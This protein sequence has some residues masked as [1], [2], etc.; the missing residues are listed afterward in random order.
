[1]KRNI[2]FGVNV[3]LFVATYAI[4]ML[5]AM[6]KID[7]PP[8]LLRSAAGIVVIQ[9]ASAM[10]ALFRSTNFFSPDTELNGDAWDL[11]A[12]LWKFQKKCFPGDAS[13]RWLLAISPAS[14]DFPDFASGFARA[15][16][17]GYIDIQPNGHLILLSSSGYQYC[18]QNEKKLSKRKRLFFIEA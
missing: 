12:T 15:R 5:A 6:K 10:V 11:L 3:V 2:L 16:K 9:Q 13:K 18:Q 8:W 4:V 1:M 17:L 14:A 7:F